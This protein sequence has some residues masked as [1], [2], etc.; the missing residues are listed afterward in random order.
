MANPPSTVPLAWRDFRFEV[1]AEW[2]IVGYSLKPEEGRLA[3][4]D[5]DGETLQIFWKKTDAPPDLDRRLNDLLRA[6]LPPRASATNGRCPIEGFHGWR[7]GLGGDRTVPLAAARYLTG[8]KRMLG[9]IFAPHPRRREEVVRAILASWAPND[10]PERR[11]TAFGLDLALPVA[12]EPEVAR[13]FPALQCLEFATRAGDRVILHRFGMLSAILEGTDP[14]THFARVKGRGIQTWRRPPSASTPRLDA[15]ELALRRRPIGW[16]SAPRRLPREG[17][18]WLWTRADVER[19]WALEIWTRRDR[20]LCADLP[21]A[22]EHAIRHHAIP[23]VR[24][25]TPPSPP[26][27]NAPHSTRRLGIAEL[28]RMIPT[29]NAAAER[30]PLPDGGLRLAIPLRR[31]RW[32]PWIGWWLPISKTRRIELDRAGVA[33]LALFDGTRTLGEVVA[34]HQRRWKLSELEARGMILDFLRPL[35]RSGVVALVMPE[36]SR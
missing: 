19:L 4:A 17:R 5:G 25:P 12:F 36:A 2:E 32:V 13:V 6:N 33:A 11:W 8:A 23:P 3:L 14:A 27:G 26:P 35:V 1:P 7:A 10:G 34:L 20:A 31:P 28:T 22:M 24:P 21:L 15:T 16:W 9:V 18:A 29:P 30:A